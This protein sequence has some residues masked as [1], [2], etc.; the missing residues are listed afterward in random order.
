MYLVWRFNVYSRFIICLGLLF[1]W[2]GTLIKIWCI[3]ISFMRYEALLTSIR[4]FL[5]LKNEFCFIFDC[6]FTIHNFYF[7]VW[8]LRSWREKWKKKKKKKTEKER[9]CCGREVIWD[10]KMFLLSSD[11][12]LNGRVLWNW[13][14]GLYS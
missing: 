9:M 13:M 12:F 5:F 8:M 1:L 11:W 10:F 2:F 6:S 3:C 4:L 7:F 14:K